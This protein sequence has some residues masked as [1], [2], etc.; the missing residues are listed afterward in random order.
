[1]ENKKFRKDAWSASPI[2]FSTMNHV[3]LRG[4]HFNAVLKEFASLL[5]LHPSGCSLMKGPF[6]LSLNGALKKII[7]TWGSRLTWTAQRHDVAPQIIA[8]TDTFFSYVSFLSSYELDA[9]STEPDQDPPLVVQLQPMGR[10]TRGHT[11]SPGLNSD[12]HQSW[13]FRQEGQIG[14][15]FLWTMESKVLGMREWMG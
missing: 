8:S 14:G 2:Q 4:G 15:I 9:P 12:W 10:N 6:A 1:M 11:H 7:N 13:V 5:V 3:G